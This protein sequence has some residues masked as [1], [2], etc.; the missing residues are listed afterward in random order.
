ML[1]YPAVKFLVLNSILI[2]CKT[3]YS[4]LLTEC[5]AQRA[6]NDSYTLLRFSSRTPKFGQIL[7]PASLLM[8]KAR[9]IGMLPTSV[10]TLLKKSVPTLKR[11]LLPWLRTVIMMPALVPPLTLG[12]TG[13]LAGLLPWPQ[14]SNVKSP[15]S[16]V[17]R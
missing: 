1:V 13:P 17:F 2:I 9:L 7:V 16:R 6:P 10:L 5:A 11:C 4:P 8:Q 14:L 12:P 15:L 3:A